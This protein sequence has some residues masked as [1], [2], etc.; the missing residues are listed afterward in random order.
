MKLVPLR[1]AAILVPI[2]AFA[3][4]PA[5]ADVLSVGNILSQFNAVVFDDFSSRSDVEGR[6]VVGGDLIGGA[7]F[8]MN[9]GDV[10]ASSFSG[11][12][13]YG[14]AT[15]GGNYNVNDGGGVTIAGSNTV[16]F[17]LNGG[18]STYI[19]GANSGNI[20][21]SGNVTV[22][23][24]NSGTLSIN[25]GASVYVGGGNSGGITVNGNASVAINGSNSA[26]VNLNGG[27]T[28]SLNGSNAATVSLSGGT[29]TYTG[30]K[31]NANLNEGATAVQASSLNLTAP[32]NTLPS[33]NSTFQA[34]LTALS[35]QLDA[36]AAN[37]AATSANN[38]ITFNAKPNSSGTAVFDIKSSFLT[39][40][41][42]VTMNLDGAT[43]VI[44]NVTV[45]GCASATCAFSLPNSLN[46][47]DPTGYA[48]RVLWNFVNATDLTFQNEFG[49]SVLA[50]LAAVTNDGPIDGTLVADNY[51]G[52]GELHSYSYTGTLP[53]GTVA[54]PAS[55]TI[56]N[57]AGTSG[58]AQVPEPGS[59]LLMATGL[60]AMAAFRRRPR[61]LSAG[62]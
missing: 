24:A 55:P 48:D 56:L 32:A 13:V 7:T 39:Q 36:V 47:N 4:T 21:G 50:P 42:T 33:F 53:D 1:L 11:L 27:G 58:S 16:S 52:N 51:S 28:V 60:A 35:A 25:S 19:G 57:F 31:G 62:R 6:T 49:G 44:I 43:S 15:R 14:S 37:S 40:N 54:P 61:R 46:F 22:G 38:A 3:T 59:L 5:R 8:Y 18:G 34:P 9:P 26:N 12:S 45:D 10:A 20:N 17:N 30:S 29:Y 41:S 2:G 23:G